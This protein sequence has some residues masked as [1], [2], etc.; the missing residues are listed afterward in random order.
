V[1]I[2]DWEWLD[3]ANVPGALDWIA[4]VLGGAGIAF[5]IWQLLRS[6]GALKAARDALVLAQGQLNRNQLLLVL[7][8]VDEIERA[9]EAALQKNS[10]RATEEA[11]SRFGRYAAETTALLT[12]MAE[13]TR[14]RDDLADVAQLASYARSRMFVDSG[15]TPPP[16]SRDIAG[17]A[18]RAIADHGQE[19]RRIAISIQNDLG[20]TSA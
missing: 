10:A 17:E 14:V 7:P 3:P 1:K 4:F 2:G 6:K 20:R 19:L 18:A 9:L 16:T 8:T 5:T 11:L 12:P 13:H 15:E